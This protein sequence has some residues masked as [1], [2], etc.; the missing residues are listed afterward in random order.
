MVHSIPIYRKITLSAITLRGLQS[1]YNTFKQKMPL[2]TSNKKERLTPQNTTNVSVIL[3]QPKE[4]ILTSVKPTKIVSCVYELSKV[5]E[6]LPK[7]RSEVV[8]GRNRPFSVTFWLPKQPVSW[9]N[10]LRTHSTTNFSENT[11][12]NLNKNS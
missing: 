3:N 9:P 6:L 1:V 5:K 8:G 12:E 10:I 4:S 7:R 2:Y 11:T